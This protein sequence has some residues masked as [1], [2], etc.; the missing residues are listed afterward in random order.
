MESYQKTN[1]KKY[2]L[3]IN[4]V[5]QIVFCFFNVFFNIY[6]YDISKNLNIVV[7]YTIAHEVFGLL[8]NFAINKF[9]NKKVASVL[10]KL[11]FILCLICTLL[12]F[13]ITA[14]RL[15]LVFIV[16][17]LY[18]TTCCFYYMPSE[19]ATMNKNNKSQMKKFVGINSALT[20][21]AA[22]LSPY[23]SG[24]IID[25]ISYYVLFAIMFV[26]SGIC[27]ILS[28]KLNIA[29]NEIEHMNKREFFKIAHKEKGIR[30]GYL[31]Y[32]L[33]RFSQNGIV[34]KLLPIIIFMR[35]GTNYSVGNYSALASFLASVVLIIYVYYSK[36]K[37]LSMYICTFFQILASILILISNS[38]VIYFIYFFTKKI[39]T[40][41]LHNEVYSTLFVLLDN[42]QLANYK[43][44]HY[45]V[46][47]TYSSS[48]LTISC[49]LCLI[50]YNF[51]NSVL[52]LSLFLA[53]ASLMQLVSTVLITKS[54]RILKKYENKEI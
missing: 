13:F 52:G 21:F 30:I 12:S 14:Q 31:G 28:T 39:T 50:F 48:A 11:S 26:C 44:E 20:V 22:V 8:L 25:F 3:I 5:M 27:F 17:I 49:L 7:F 9:I 19:V 37:V 46:Y 54:D 38:I 36:N 4:L 51:F 43:V 32:S 2:I 10:F 6:V 33:C 1:D 24:Y 53:F 40:K 15:Y 41:L 35:M 16:Q 23:L 18:A 34:E 47:N 45:L 42:T 29:T